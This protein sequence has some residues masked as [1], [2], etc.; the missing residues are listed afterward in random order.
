MLHITSDVQTLCIVHL[1]AKIGFQ[2]NDAVTDLKLV[3]K[4]LS[5]EDLAL[6]V[7]IDFPFQILGGY[8]AANWSKGEHKLRPWIHG[9]WVRLAFAVWSML[10]VKGFPKSG[11]S[12]DVPFVFLLVVIVSKVLSSFA[13]Y[14]MGNR[15]FAID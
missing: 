13:G 9:Y 6:V 12:G 5:K 14:V 3:E 2:A 8:F 10:L 7:L 4:G 15:F 1:L 11:K